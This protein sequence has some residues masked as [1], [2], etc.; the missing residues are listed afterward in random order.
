VKAAV[1]F[2]PYATDVT[3]ASHT[4]GLARHL[5]NPREFW[6]PY[7]VPSSSADDPLFNAD[8][9]AGQAPQLP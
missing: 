4:A 7:P 8:A 9:M 3:D 2:Y 5:F 1:C 6:T